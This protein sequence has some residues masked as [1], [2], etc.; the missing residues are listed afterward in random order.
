MNDKHIQM[1]IDV[2]LYVM[3]EILQDHE[4][5]IEAYLL[6]RVNHFPKTLHD[7]EVSL[8]MK[9]DNIRCV[10][11]TS[12]VSIYDYNM[13]SENEKYIYLQNLVDKNEKIED[14]YD[15]KYLSMYP[16]LFKKYCSKLNYINFTTYHFID[17]IDDDLL[18][19]VLIHKIKHPKIMFNGKIKDMNISGKEFE[20]MKKFDDIM[21]LYAKS[22]IEIDKRQLM[23]FPDKYL[24]IYLK[25]R[26]YKDDLDTY[27]IDL[28]DKDMQNKVF[29]YVEDK[30][31]FEQKN[32]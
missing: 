24:Q 2:G 20:K 19:F 32:V 17:N 30:N 4:N 18:R 8:I 22:G 7:W 10:Y 14:L 12:G 26:M 6:S 1:F 3:R 23:E 15:I 13:L 27:E 11:I 5:L 28:M 9:K 21:L 25:N 31:K 16:D 29:Q